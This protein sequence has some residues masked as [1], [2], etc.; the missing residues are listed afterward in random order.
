MKLDVTH[1]KTETVNVTPLEMGRALFSYVA[2]EILEGLDDAGCDWFTEDGRV[3]I[4]GADWQ[5]STDNNTAKLV[6]AANILI[7]GEIK[8]F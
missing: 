2:N 4:G 3:Y 7:Y 6:D 8:T 1:T 5:V